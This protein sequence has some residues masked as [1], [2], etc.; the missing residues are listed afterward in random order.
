MS[1][2][3]DMA[4]IAN[5]GCQ[6]AT[7]LVAYEIGT[8]DSDRDIH[9]LIEDILATAATIGEL[10]EFLAADACAD[11]PVYKQA[12]RE[13]IEDLV[14]RCGA[15]YTTI[16]RSVYRASLHVKIVE[17]VDFQALG[18]EDLKAS[19]IRAI[20]ANMDWNLVSNA[21]N[22]SKTHLRW[23]KAG[24]LLHLQ[25]AN[26]ARLQNTSRA[27][28][29]FDEELA[30]RA[31]AM[32]MLACKVKAAKTIVED[33]ERKDRMAMADKSDTASIAS[34]A[35]S[36]DGNKSDDDLASWTSGKTANDTMA[37]WMCGGK[38]VKKSG[39]HATVEPAALPSP[40]APTS[41]WHQPWDGAPDAGP[42]EIKLL[43]PE[44]RFPVKAFKSMGKWFRGLFGR[45]DIPCL[46]DL[47]EL[48]A[49]VLR[50]GP[51]PEA[52]LAFEPRM[53]RL[54]LKRI[55][56]HRTNAS[57]DAFLTQDTELRAAVSNALLRAQKKDGRV[58]QLVTVDLSTNPDV[59]IVFMSVEPALE[60]IHMTDI[61]GRKYDIPYEQGRT[62]QGARAS[63]HQRFRSANRLWP[64]I[65]DGAFEVVAEDDTVVTPEAWVTT[66]KPGA[67]MRMRMS[68][69][70]DGGMPGPMYTAPGA[71]E[72]LTWAERGPGWRCNRPQ[73]MPLGPTCFPGARPGRMAGPPPPPRPPVFTVKPRIADGAELGFE[74]DFGPPLT[75]E[76]DIGEGRKD[77]G[78]WVALWTNATDTDFTTDSGGIPSYDDASSISSG[79]SSSIIDY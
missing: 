37:S 14:T 71:P 78:R 46:N 16:I 55:L 72:I 52:F 4:G 32:R 43:A 69:F 62:V 21:F 45:H 24:L 74:L 40:A 23:L 12:G 25:V 44:H 34:G 67:V 64:I 61:V 2:S 75:R 9:S 33:L 47:G 51:F 73:G 27:P 59:A 48:E 65:R 26:I 28:G 30:S 1:P 50:N 10:R 11:L 35:S 79:S 54:E 6:L 77:L 63:I 13:A 39:A 18:P 53:L 56:K 49:T 57:A 68:A 76:D 29:S 70:N 19:R 22:T 66:I 42:V 3:T 5:L 15:V 58:R 60:P 41:F 31:L 8:S 17:N 20:H 36:S 38:A 7:K